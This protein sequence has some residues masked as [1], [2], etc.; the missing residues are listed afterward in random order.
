[1]KDCAGKGEDDLGNFDDHIGGGSVPEDP[2]NLLFP[3]RVPFVFD[4]KCFEN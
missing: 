3:L 1:M 4:R 2:P